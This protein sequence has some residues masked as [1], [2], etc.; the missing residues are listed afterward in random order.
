[1]IRADRNFQAAAIL[2]A[3]GAVLAASVAQAATLSTLATFS[4]KAGFPSSPQAPVSIDS[5]GDLFGTT[6]LGGA[7]AVGTLFELAAPNFSPTTLATFGA[8]VPKPDTGQPTGPLVAVNKSYFGTGII[9]SNTSGA[10]P[11]GGCGGVY[12]YTTTKPSAYRIFH[13]F[14]GI[15]DGAVPSGGLAKDT[16]TQTYVFGTTAY[17]GDGSK[18]FAADPGHGTVFQMSVAGNSLQKYQVIYRIASGPGAYPFAGP[19]LDST[20]NIYIAGYFGDIIELQR[21]VSQGGAWTPVTITTGTGTTV[22]SLTIDTKGLLK[23]QPAGA[24]YGVNFN[25]SPGGGGGYGDVFQLVPPQSGQ[26]QWTVNYIYVF[27]DTGD[28]VFPKSALTITQSGA[29]R[30]TTQGTDKAGD[31]GEYG[32]IF[33]LEPPASGSTAWTERALHTFEGADG[34]DPLASLAPGKNGVFYGTTSGGTAGSVCGTV[35]SLSP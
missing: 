20:G 30:G 3:G 8:F 33:Q 14:T 2:V 34:G 5:S 9:N 35:F 15:A 4:C 24:I 25:P 10:C 32:N 17:G 7:H 23:G 1:M 19:L 26:T 21:P 6:R 31:V 16:V 22:A 27:N 29:L 13:S 12:G 11:T 18:N 28:G